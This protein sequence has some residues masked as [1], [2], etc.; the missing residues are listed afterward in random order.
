MTI[1]GIVILSRCITSKERKT[2][3]F[4]LPS[5]SILC[6][7]KK[8]I[9]DVHSFCFHSSYIESYGVHSTV[10]FLSFSRLTMIAISTI[11]L[12]VVLSTCNGR[13]TFF[14]EYECPK[15]TIDFTTKVENSSFVVFGKSK[16]KTLA[17]GS[18]S[19]FHVNF[20]VDCIFKGPAI[21]SVINITQAGR[22]KILYLKFTKKRSFLQVMSKVKRTVKIFLLLEVMRLRF[23]NEIHWI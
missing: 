20:Q 17:E 10:I 6:T 2:I 4:L 22:N 12:L 8:H 15:D 18:D 16:G 1:Q 7:K 14:D 23:S 11:F 19:V 3:V 9:S 13:A 21:P 5:S